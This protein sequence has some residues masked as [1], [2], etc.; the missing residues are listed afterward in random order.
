MR[1]LS[2]GIPILGSIALLLGVT[3]CADENPW[4]NTS[5]EKGKIR[6]SLTTNSHIDSAKP[7]FRSGEDE[8]A[9]NTADLSSYITVPTPDQFSIHLERADGSYS[10]TWTTLA[11]FKEEANTTTFNT[12]SYT[13]TAFYGEKGTQDFEAPYFEA[14]S[15]FT[16]LSEQTQEISLEAELKNSMVKVNYTQGFIDYMKEDYYSTIHTEGLTEDLTYRN[17]ETRPAFIE[18]NKAN[19]TVHFTTKDKGHSADVSLG[20]FAPIAK[21]LHNI[22]FDIGENQYG[23]TT[24]E[25]SFDETLT[26]DPVS[27]DL[28]DELWT[29]PAPVITWENGIENG[30]TIDMLEGTA[31]DQ[32]L[33]M[34]VDAEGIIQ[35][36]VL[37]VQSTNYTPAWGSEIDLCSANSEQI[38]QIQSAGI[39]ATG[40]G[41]TGQPTDKLAF[42]NLTNFGKS[43]PKGEH[44]ISLVVTDQTGKVSETASVKLNSEEITVEKIGDPTIVYGSGQAVLTLDYNGQN[45]GTD[46]SFTAIGSSG[47]HEDAS[48]ASWEDITATR[49]FEKKRYIYTVNLPTTTKSNIEIKVFHKVTN[50]VA[51]FTVPVTVPAYSITQYDAFSKYAYLK[52]TTESTDAN[53]LTAVINNLVIKGNGNELTIAN[54]NTSTGVVTLS[55]LTPATTYTVTSSITGDAWNDNNS[56]TTETELAIPNGDFTQINSTNLTSG[57]LQVGGEWY[58]TMFA[59]HTHKSSFSYSIPSEWANVNDLTAWSQAK[60]RNTWYVV[61]SSWVENGMGVMRNVGYHHNGRKVNKTGSAA[62]TTYYCTDHPEDSELN[63]AAGELFLG[64]YSYNGNESRTEGTSFASRPKSISFEYQ[65]TPI[66]NDIGYA[67]IDIFDAEDNPIGNKQAIA[68]KAS[69]E[70]KTV[71]V[72]FNYNQFGKKATTL[73]VS[74]KS[75]NNATP[76]IHIPTGKELDE[77]TGTTGKT[78]PANTYHAVATGSVLKIDNVTAHYGDAPGTTPANAPKRKTTKRK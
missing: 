17:I 11:A 54:R 71:N 32:I 3:G 35:N 76:P 42:L 30:A 38:Q 5:K 58:I 72:D 12:G 2:F 23:D 65:Y 27:I 56:F 73:K 69:S 21:T 47:R 34:R 40:F 75:S 68:L 70:S 46:I 52:V 44:T 19:V 29:T 7:V 26:E 64:S 18:P 20:E 13:L 61:P 41:L 49:A 45:P 22:T 55:G 66:N 33:K 1:H 60:N 15:T 9:D 31:S 24:L 77:G 14:S 62:G 8:S 28:T 10:K 37:T 78:L 63:K 16:V 39:E 25:V 51:T 53:V 43:L 74:F 4:G 67:F 6:L 48:I 59:T 50:N 36:A 57:E